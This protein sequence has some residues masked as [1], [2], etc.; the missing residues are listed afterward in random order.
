[1]KN[2]MKKLISATLLTALFTSISVLAAGE[3]IY[4][5]GPGNAVA[6]GSQVSI[7][8]QLDTDISINA[9]D[10]EVGYP[11]D[12]LEFLDFNNENSI[13]DIWQTKPAILPN[14]NIGFSGGIIKS[15]SGTKGLIG[16]LSFS[17]KTE[18]SP[19]L[20]LPKSD[21]YLADGQGTKMSAPTLNLIFSIKDNG[22]IVVS[23]VVPFKSTPAD[24][25]IEKQLETLKA[26]GSRRTLIYWSGAGALVVLSGILMYNKR[27]R[28]QQLK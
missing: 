19:K 28:R 8:V 5:T 2:K 4:F 14:G 22:Q 10:L 26:E 21:I 17:A 13:I 3:K 7:S 9:L 12:T 16:K 11:K 15:F 24:I 18:G 23:P 6:P 20:S 25:E 27:K 1:M